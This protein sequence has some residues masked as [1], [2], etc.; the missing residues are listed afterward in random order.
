MPITQL[1]QRSV[2]PVVW[3]TVTGLPPDRADRPG[4]GGTNDDVLDLPARVQR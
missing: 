4:P 1:D 3:V 2:L